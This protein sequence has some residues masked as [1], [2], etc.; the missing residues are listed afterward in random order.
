MTPG[1]HRYDIADKLLYRLEAWARSAG[2]T[3]SK[4]TGNT[5]TDIEGG[6]HKIMDQFRRSGRKIYF[7]FDEVQRFFQVDDNP[8]YVLFKSLLLVGKYS[9]ELRFIFTGSGMVRT[10][11]EIAKCPA[12]GT[13]VGAGS[14]PIY[15]PATDP[16]EVLEKTTELLLHQHKLDDGN[17]DLNDLLSTMPSAAG[18]SH[19]VLQWLG[20][21]PELRTFKEVGDRVS[22]KYEAEFKA[23]MLPLLEDLCSLGKRQDLV[24]L[25]NLAQGDATEDPKSWMPASVYHHFLSHYIHKSCSDDGETKY[26][27]PDTPLS[28]ILM[29]HIGVEGDLLENQLR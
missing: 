5:Y 11:A 14:W 23:D 3:V 21:P 18:R 6:L 10:W 26:S 13:T 9:G 27:L 1:S 7:L 22:T 15:L 24:Q 12:N 28:V 20:T 19:V 8:D 16:P 25:R 17:R 2:I 4:R 29:E